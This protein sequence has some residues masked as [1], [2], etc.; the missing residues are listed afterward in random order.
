VVEPI[1]L[2]EHPSAQNVYALSRALKL[3]SRD[4]NKRLTAIGFLEHRTDRT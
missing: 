1:W 2:I 4:L 3:A